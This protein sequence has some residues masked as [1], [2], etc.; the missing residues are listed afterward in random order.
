MSMITVMVFCKPMLNTTHA[1]PVFPSGCF[2]L[3]FFFF[4]FCFW[5]WSL[6]QIVYFLRKSLSPCVCYGRVPSWDCFSRCRRFFTKACAS[7]SPLLDSSSLRM[8]SSG[9]STQ[10]FSH[11]RCRFEGRHVGSNCTRRIIQ[12]CRTRSRHRHHFISA[13]TWE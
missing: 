8:L 10:R 5:Y 13:V 1:T 3:H 7:R 2:F 4:P 11:V 12:M 6:K 9:K